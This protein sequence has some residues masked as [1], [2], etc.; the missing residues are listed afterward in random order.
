[1]TKTKPLPASHL[2]PYLRRRIGYLLNYRPSVRAD[3]RAA[4]AVALWRVHRLDEHP[5]LRVVLDDLAGVTE[6]LRTLYALQENPLTGGRPA[7]NREPAD[8]WRVDFAALTRRQAVITDRLIGSRWNRQRCGH[9]LAAARPDGTCEEC[10]MRT[11]DGV[12][13]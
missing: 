8:L 3:R 4:Y 2:P 13:R 11:F 7:R 1:M 5:A 9:D 6:A 12:I 10:I